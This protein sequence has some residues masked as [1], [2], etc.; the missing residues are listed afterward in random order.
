[1]VDNEAFG[2]GVSFVEGGLDDRFGPLLDNISDRFVEADETTSTQQVQQAKHAEAMVQ[3]KEVALQGEFPMH[4]YPP[5]GSQTFDMRRNLRLVGPTVL[6]T[7][8]DYTLPEGI[9]GFWRAY[10]L[11]SDVPA[12]I[13]AMWT[14]YLNDQP[15]F[16]FHGDPL[17]NFKITLALGIDLSSEID[18][19]LEL[20]GGDHIKVVGELSAPVAAPGAAIA[21]R[22]KGWFIAKALD[23]VRRGG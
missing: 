6:A 8:I 9:Q 21:F 20:K 10:S 13:N 14:V 12:G 23:M 15:C 2:N 17:N 18:A 19:L 1:M 22:M 16:P 7:L 11:Y 5:R 3:Q 4:L